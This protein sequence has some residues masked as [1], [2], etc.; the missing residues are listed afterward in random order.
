MS[1]GASCIPARAKIKNSVADSRLTVEVL[2]TGRL[3]MPLGALS[4]G[5][6]P[7][8]HSARFFEFRDGKI[9]SQRSYDCFEAW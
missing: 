1:R 8:A 7:R 2:W 5:G 6:E 3:A 9:A 4:A